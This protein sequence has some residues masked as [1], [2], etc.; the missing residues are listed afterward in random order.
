MLNV[1]FAGWPM[2]QMEAK[3]SQPAATT[4]AALKGDS[5]IFLLIASQATSG[6][7]HQASLEA[8]QMVIN[9]HSPES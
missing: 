8:H 7:E 2:V 4:E 1:F 5:R 3:H 6:L 9:L